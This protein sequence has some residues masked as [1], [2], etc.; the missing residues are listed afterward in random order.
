MKTCTCHVLQCLGDVRDSVL[1]FLHGFLTVCEVIFFF[2]P[3][4]LTLISHCVFIFIVRPS[5]AFVS[6]LVFVFESGACLI[7]D[8]L[9]TRYLGAL[10]HASV[11][12]A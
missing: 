5:P 9:G 3:A 11:Y 10:S 1:G 4:A 2:Y 12:T 7:S 8:W 6:C